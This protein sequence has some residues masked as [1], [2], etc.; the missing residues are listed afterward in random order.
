MNNNKLINL[1]I[2]SN[3][4]DGVIKN[5][6]DTNSLLDES[7]CLLWYGTCSTDG[8]IDMNNHKIVNISDPTKNQ[9]AVTKNYLVHY[10]DNLKTNRSGDFV[11]GDLNMV[12]NVIINILNPTYNQEAATK[13]Y[14]DNVLNGL[15]LFSSANAGNKSLTRVYNIG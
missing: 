13:N 6:C 12:N 2:L 15:N 14:V 4:Q 7:N 1:S 5:F 3:N 8:N 10:H 11:S 9:D